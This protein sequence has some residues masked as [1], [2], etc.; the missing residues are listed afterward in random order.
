MSAGGFA[1]LERLARLRQLFFADAFSLGQTRLRLERQSGAYPEHQRWRLGPVRFA[2]LNVLGDDNHIGTRDEASAEFQA[3]NPVVLA[4]LRDSFALAR[5]EQATAIVQVMQADPDFKRF[6][7]GLGH[8]GFRAL[9]Q[10]LRQET[11][12]FPGPVVLP[13]ID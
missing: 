8:R 7:A 3:R 4:W 5:R 1:P 10:A 2:T 12:S 9:L 13:R 6:A 11:M